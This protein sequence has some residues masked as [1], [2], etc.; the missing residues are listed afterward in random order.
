MPASASSSP[1]LC[2]AD[3]EVNLRAG[4]LFKLGNKVRI[5]ERPFQVL[6]VLLERAGEV[7]TREELSRR[8]WPADT[9]VDFDHSLAVAINKVREALGDSAEK[10]RFVE[11]V[12]RRATASWFRLSRRSQ[13]N[14]EKVS[15]KLQS[16]PRPR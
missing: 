6:S 8:V 16:H 14:S 1:L 2:F 13:S 11:T 4:E 10:P 15:L 5:Q 9:F 3:F 12:G 7:V